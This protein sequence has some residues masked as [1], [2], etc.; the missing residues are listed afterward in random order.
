M[1]IFMRSFNLYSSMFAQIINLINK[2]YE[3]DF[4]FIWS[5]VSIVKFMLK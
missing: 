2:Y 1:L 3:K 4:I 5:L